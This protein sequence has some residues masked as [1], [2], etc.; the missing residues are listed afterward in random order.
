MGL[1]RH[2]LAL[3]HPLVRHHIQRTTPDAHLGRLLSHPPTRH[4]APEERL[5]TDH[6]RLAQRPTVVPRLLL[7]RR[8]TDPPDAAEVLIPDQPRSRRVTMPLDLRIP[9]GRDY[10]TSSTPLQF[11]VH[12]TTIIHPVRPHARDR[13]LHLLQQGGDHLRIRHPRL[14]D[15][16]RLDLT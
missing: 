13:V 8:P 10:R 12:R 5:H 4:T 9:P 2:P 14:A 15:H 16:R 6:R 7:P 11:L 3:R 1:C